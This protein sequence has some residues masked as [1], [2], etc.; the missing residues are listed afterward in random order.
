M[1]PKSIDEIMES[2]LQ[3]KQEIQ[4]FKRAYDSLLT[5]NVSL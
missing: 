5:Q 3:E 4:E 2:F 1:P